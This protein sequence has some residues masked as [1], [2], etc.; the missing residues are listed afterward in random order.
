MFSIPTLTDVSQ[1]MRRIV[2]TMIPGARADFWPHNLP[3][4]I[5]TFALA[6]YDALLRARWVYK[7][8]FIASCSGSHLDVHGA[9]LGI[10]RAGAKAATGSASFT[11]SAATTVPLGTVFVSDAGVFY[12]STAEVTG[13]LGA[14]IAVPLAAQEAAAAGNAP[15]GTI[16]RVV[17]SN[18]SP[19]P[20]LDTPGTLAS[21]AAGGANIEDDEPY[22]A[23]ILERL[24]SRPRGGNADDY[25]FWVKQSGVFN[26]VA[27]RGW[28]PS[29][30][31]V[32]LYP[33]KPGSGSERIPTEGELTTLAEHI[34]TV[35]PLCA[36]IVLA[37][38]S[39]QPINIVISGLE[40]DNEGVRREIA[41]ELDDMFDERAK[42][43]LPG[44]STT[45][46]R[47][48]I[49]EAISRARG[50]DRDILVTPAADV[51]LTVGAFPTRGTIG[52]V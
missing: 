28:L 11:L 24:R 15:S 52:Y 23:R 40:P 50:E 38:A 26:A 46:S 8:I 39:V 25:T 35:R 31:R 10:P 19:L 18:T 12:L 27:V 14:T 33:L 22:R 16:V 41:A 47:S 34:E 30:G 7:Q 17:L 51:S 21:G 36:E 13:A 37:Q 29:A 6:P 45:F 9:E 42:V 4:I 44:E 2:P 48:W 3:I 20:G 1:K 49:S 5:T 32:T 43:A